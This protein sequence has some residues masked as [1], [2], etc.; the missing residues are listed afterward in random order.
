MSVGDVGD[1]VLSREGGVNVLAVVRGAESDGAGV[2]PASGPA[3][4]LL[5]ASVLS[6]AM[7]SAAI[8]VIDFMSVDDGLDTALEPLLDQ[9]R[10]TLRRRRA[11]ADTLDSYAAEVNDRVD[12]DDYGAGAKILFLFGIHRAREL[13]SEMGSLDVDTELVEKL[14]RVMRDGPEVGIYVW[15]W[16][17]S[18]AGA[19]RRLTPR[20]MR[21]AGWRIA[22]KMSADDSQSLLGTGQAGD[23]RESQLI[24]ANDDRGVAIRVISYSLPSRGWVERL[25]TPTTAKNE[26]NRWVV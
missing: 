4:G 26:E 3:Y 1:L 6:A 25:L 23:L 24:L 8:D 5:V 10:I 14:E 7:T 18:V 20:M 12:H 17:D 22:G 9:G 11:F 13:D 15:V 21:E 19:S 16:A 2:E